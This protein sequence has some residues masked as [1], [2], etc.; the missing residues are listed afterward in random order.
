MSVAKILKGHNLFANLGVEEVNKLSGF[1]ERRTYRKGQLLFKYGDKAGHVFIL[2]EGKVH[3]R[4]P[5]KSDAFRLVISN[6]AKGDFFGLS[7]LLG[8]ERYT[9]EAQADGPTQALAVDALKLRSLLEENC[10]EEPRKPIVHSTG[11]QRADG[12]S[13]R[14]LGIV[15]FTDPFWWQDSLARR[16]VTHRQQAGHSAH[17]PGASRP[18]HSG[19]PDS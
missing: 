17:V 10:L 18:R 5:A 14:I 7:P 8:S 15:S 16:H 1:S 6:V 12:P 11:S 13:I 19:P 3:L 9:L 4:L 2:L